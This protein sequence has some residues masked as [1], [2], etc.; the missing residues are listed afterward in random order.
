[1]KTIDRNRLASVCDLQG[2]SLRTN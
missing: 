2:M 1:M